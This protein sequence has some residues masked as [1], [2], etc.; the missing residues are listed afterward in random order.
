MADEA[1]SSDPSRSNPARCFSKHYTPPLSLSPDDHSTHFVSP[2]FQ[3]DIRW[4]SGLS[5][6]ITD[7]VGSE[8]DTWPSHYTPKPDAGFSAP[9]AIVFVVDSIDQDHLVAARSELDH[10][11]RCDDLKDTVIVV[12]ANKQGYNEKGSLDPDQVVE[13]LGLEGATD[14]S[15]TFMTC[16]CNSGGGLVTMLQLIDATRPH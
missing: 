4:T 12:A 8:P 13:R 15:V 3:A 16:S 6:K 11:L 9:Y 5:Y 2:Y 14:R 10:L 1:R 7:V